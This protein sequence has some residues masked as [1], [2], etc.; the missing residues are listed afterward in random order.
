M[1]HPHPSP[2]L[3]PAAATDKPG[4]PEMRARIIDKLQ[5]QVG[6]SPERASPRDWFMATA[7]AVRDGVVECWFD[8][9]RR[10]VDGAAKRVYYLSLE[11]L[12]GRLLADTI[13]N[14][15]LTEIVREALALE[16]VDFD[17]LREREP[18]AALGNGG[19]GRLAACFMESMATL[20][21]NCFGYGIRYEHGLFKQKITDGVQEEL[22]EDWLSFGNPWEFERSEF[23]YR[24]G[25]GGTVAATPDGTGQLP[26][27]LA[28][29]RA[30]PRRRLRHPRHRR[31]RRGT[32][33]RSGSG[34][35]AR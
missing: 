18:D 12:I 3:A 9:R 21:I 5:Y 23:A 16:G 30:D 33:T 34:P 13:G 20:E 22:P 17:E 25:F 11:F 28:P 15:G 4:V 27:H 1:D 7:F 6:K 24:I 8:S 31:R 32:P 26:L 14:L 2:D 19:L 35:P 29:R 10:S